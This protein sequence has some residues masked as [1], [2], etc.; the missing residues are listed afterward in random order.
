MRQWLDSVQF[1]SMVQVRQQLTEAG[2]VDIVSALASELERLGLLQRLPR[3]ARV[4]VAVGSRGIDR[5]AEI[6]R[7]TVDRLR[8]AGTRPFIVPAMGSHGGATPEGQ[9][10][11]LADYGITEATIGVPIDAKMDAEV[12]GNTGDGVAVFMSQA[13]RQADGILLV[14][15]VKP[16]TD[17]GGAIGSGLI[18]ML[19]VGLGKHAGALSFHRAAQR[20]GH[21]RALR[22]M[23]AASRQNSGDRLIG[24][25]AIIEDSRHQ[26]ARLELVPGRDLEQSESR[27]AAEAA[28]HMP[29]LPLEEIDLLILD[30]IG[31]NISGTGMDPNVIGRMIHGYSLI[32][33]E[34]PKHPRIRRIFVRDLSPESHGNAI[35]IGMAD[36]TTERL[37]HAMD[38][39][40]TYM[41][42]LTALSLQ[43]AK[44]PVVFPNDRQAV[45]AALATLGLEDTR[46]ARVVRIVDTLSLADMQVSQVCLEELR[47]QQ[48]LEIVGETGEMVF[49]AQGDLAR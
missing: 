14:N 42:A 17:F 16:H 39:E 15:R 34:L 2:P 44:V 41:N 43:G 33:T 10:R 7:A 3:N 26:T 5:L 9:L 6:I 36:F 29:R 31:K 49:D 18:K 23:A 11:L 46:Q 12:S 8:A 24:G 30:R 38:R 40:V 28:R 32:E 19:V 35:G 4:A 20:M 27:L 25:L 1:P 13:A 45:A 22:T 48:Q 47:E 21:E 37:V